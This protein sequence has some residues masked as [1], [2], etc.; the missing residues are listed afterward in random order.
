MIDAANAGNSDAASE[1]LP[2]VYDELRR[3]ASSK[4]AQEAPGQTLQPTALVHEA[5]IKLLGGEPIRWQGRRHF[6]ALAATA[7]RRI[8]VDRARAKRARVHGGGRSR[9]DV[10]IEMTIASP[11]PAAEDPVDLLGLD[12]ALAALAAH[13]PR[14]AEVV[15]LRFFAGLSI[16]RT[17]EVMDLSPATVK[18][19]WM[20]ARAWLRRRMERGGTRA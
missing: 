9:S 19:E 4:L 2:L 7:M 15:S 3:L 10:D 17:A 8:L 18:N 16:E 13:D 1:L 12:D 14:Q 5:Y 20:Y 11:T 6:F